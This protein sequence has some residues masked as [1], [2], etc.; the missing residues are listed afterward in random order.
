MPCN[1]SPR[2]TCAYGTTICKSTSHWDWGAAST[3]KSECWLIII[4]SFQSSTYP[5]ISMTASQPSKQ[6]VE[7]AS[8]G[9]SIAHPLLGLGLGGS[10]IPEAHRR[11]QSPVRR[12]RPSKT[13]RQTV[14]IHTQKHSTSLLEAPIELPFQT[15]MMNHTFYLSQASK[16]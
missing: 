14:P 16:S 10:Q 2:I 7:G 8:G 3:V 9:E 11:I 13:D 15:L 6:L 1:A 4:S 12:E 5:I